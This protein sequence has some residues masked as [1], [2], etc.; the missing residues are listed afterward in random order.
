LQ[1][2]TPY[3]VMFWVKPKAGTNNWKF[4]TEEA[5]PPA[6]P[7]PT[8]TNDGITTGF[9]PVQQMTLEVTT[10]RSP[11]HAVINV[12]LK[13]DPKSA[14]VLMLQ[15]I[16]PPAFIF[17]STGCGAMCQAGQALGVTGRRTATI[18]SSTGE[19]L[20]TMTHTIFVQTPQSTPGGVQNWFV[21]ARGQGQ[22]AVTGWGEGTG[23]PVMQMEAG[24][25]YAGIS[26]LRSAQISFHFDLKVNAGSEIAIEP[27]PNYILSCSTQGALKVGSLPGTKPGCTDEPL[28]LML[29]KPMVA[30]TYSFA[31]A[32]DLPAQLPA[33]NAFNIVIR[34][35]NNNVVDA[36]YGIAGQ[37][38]KVVPT[39]SP[40][41]AWTRSEI[42]QRTVI[43]ISITF[44]NDYSLVKALL[45]TLPDTF[46]QNVMNP[47]EVK[48]VNRRFPVAASQAQGW[49][50]TT[51]QNKLKIE[52]DDS[53]SNTVIA[54]GTYS[55]NFPVM[56][57]SKAVPRKNVWYFSLCSSRLCKTWDGKYVIVSFPMQG[58]KVGEVSPI[59][60]VNQAN[61]ARR[62]ASS[63]TLSFAI[64]CIVPALFTLM[65]LCSLNA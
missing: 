18:A 47:S 17:P 4:S 57:P 42:N 9:K 43:S 7:Y 51:E 24:V 6:P 37:D 38:I 23:F 28:V 44:T 20:T 46:V 14:I 60:A 54:A 13:I 1:A 45:I 32:V 58:F 25:A 35:Q 36:K 8:N 50:V 49:A 22:G 53:D 10:P 39:T 55:W 52:L 15:I 41:L 5:G 11:P 2:D 63:L 56:M 26:S 59:V 19:A 61:G 40:T 12:V 27:P 30:G 16:A 3:T 29:S 34:D 65:S 21:E 31:I 48:N 33:S 64:G 62:F